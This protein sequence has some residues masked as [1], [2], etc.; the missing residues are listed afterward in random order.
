[1]QK[2]INTIFLIALISLSTQMAHGR[3][4][5]KACFNVEGMT[6]ATCPLTVKAAVKKIAGV[7][8][9]SASVE[10]KNAEVT[11]DPAQTNAEAIGKAITNVGYKATPKRCKNSDG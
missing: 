1:M 9:V 5:G 6:C 2:L 7:Q 10:K 3:E 8:T 4:I 11:F